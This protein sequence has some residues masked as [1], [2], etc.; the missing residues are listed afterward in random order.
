MQK[1]HW[2]TC[3]HLP[4]INREDKD[5]DNDIRKRMEEGAKKKAEK[6]SQFVKFFCPYVDVA[7]GKSCGQ[8]YYSFKYDG[9]KKH[10]V[11]CVHY[12]AALFTKYIKE[13]NIDVSM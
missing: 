1:H 8:Y 7:T 5:R 4:Q 9:A 2:A 3:A 12:D 6:R 10:L 11:N 13:K